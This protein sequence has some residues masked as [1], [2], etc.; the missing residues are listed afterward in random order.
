FPSSTA[1]SIM[2]W[3]RVVPRSL[4]PRRHVPSGAARRLAARRFAAHAVGSRARLLAA[5]FRAR[6][7]VP[8]L[9]IYPPWSVKHE[10]ACR[11]VETSRAFVGP[12]LST[13]GAH[14]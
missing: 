13:D 4:V 8:L 10:L 3:V 11:T 2:A 14:P 12:A 1:P 9:S 7:A 6:C 5:W